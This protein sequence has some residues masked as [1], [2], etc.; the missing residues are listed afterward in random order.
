MHIVCKAAGGCLVTCVVLLGVGCGSGIRSVA[1]S[2][3][4]PNPSPNPVSGTPATPVSPSTPVLPAAPTIPVVP[5]TPNNP[6]VPSAPV[7]PTIPSAPAAPTPPIAPTDVSALNVSPATISAHVGSITRI[8]ASA[9]SQGSLTQDVTSHTKW[10]AGS[11][12]ASVSPDGSVSCLRPGATTLTAFYPPF[13]RTAN[14]SCSLSSWTTPSYFTEQSDEFVGPF[15]SW[16]N[17]QKAFGAVGDGVTDDTAAIQKAFDSIN[18]PGASP[19]LWF[20]AGTYLLRGTVTLTHKQTFSIIGEDPQ[21]TILKWEGAPGGTMLRTDGAQYFRIIRFTFDGSRSAA[22]AE[23][24]NA[25]TPGGYYTTFNELSDQHIMALKVGIDLAVAAETTIERVFFDRVSGYGVKTGNFNTLNI[26]VNDSLFV[27]CGTGVSN[28][29][30]AGNFV[31][32][33]SFFSRSAVADMSIGNTGY[34]T[35]RHNTSVNS[36]AF[37]VA[38]AIGA[39]PAQITI[40][41]NTILD[42]AT[43]P[44][45]LGNQGPL[46]VIDNIIRM[47]DQTLPAIQGFYDDTVSKSVFSMGNT[48]TTI[49]ATRSDAAAAFQGVVTAYDDSVVEPSSIP[50][51]KI[52]SNVYVPPNMKRAIFEVPANATGSGIQSQVDRAAASGHKGAVIH[53]PAGAYHLDKTLTLPLGSDLQIIGDDSYVCTLLWDGGAGGSAVELASNNVSLRSFRLRMGNGIMVDGVRVPLV[54][55][56]TTHILID[57]AQLQDGNDFS[58]NFDGVEHATAELFSTYTLGSITGVNV[59]AG[60]FRAAKRGALGITN[61]YTG[62][63]QS[64]G[65]GTSFD[66]SMG[67]KF[68]VQDNW[69]DLGETSPR[70]FILSG[71]GT[72]TEQVGAVYMNS[73]APFEI[74]DFEGKVSLIGLMFTGGFITNPGH[75]TTQLLTLGLDGESPNYLPQSN[76]NLVVNNVLDEYMDRGGHQISSQAPTDAQWMREMLAQTRSEYPSPRLPMIA[77]GSRKRL[78]RLQVDGFASAVH[79]VPSDAPGLLFYT[80]ISTGGMLTNIAGSEQCSTVF[81]GGSLSTAA[82]M[83]QDAGDGDYILTDAAGSMAL[84][85]LDGTTVGMSALNSQYGQRWIIQ[86]L[87]DGRRSLRNR[88]VDKALAWIPGSCPQLTADTDSDSAKWTLVAH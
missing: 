1:V 20:P 4:P 37:F 32:S 52:P 12:V 26:F 35:A 29:D 45:Q 82:W 55:Q 3:T 39:N 6:A 75:G 53:L 31:V 74:D 16:T 27:D 40:Q 44:L 23:D 10:S 62:S 34:F 9:A 5:T 67:G 54:D 60:P 79:I 21:T 43:I 14:V 88:A 64:E 65:N 22:I 84:G 78:M 85:L 68:M 81:Q 7:V 87:G 51:V 49:V 24:I 72:V 2:T 86:D 71:S 48:Y 50:D 11:S 56:P 80:L 15:A 69:H 18:T 70:N 77:G 73:A 76:G 28:D 46:M 66:V 42:P 41:N 19:V 59:T 63:L 83:L 61:F 38:G 58:V 47:Q 13:T 8:T 17:V 25:V 30:G 33:N 36:R 57:Q